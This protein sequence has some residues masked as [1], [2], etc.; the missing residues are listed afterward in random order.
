METEQIQAQL[1]IKKTEIRPHSNAISHNMINGCLCNAPKRQEL[2]KN[3]AGEMQR[4]HSRCCGRKGKFFQ[5]E[6][7]LCGLPRPCFH[8]STW[9]LYPPLRMG[10]A[11]IIHPASA[12]NW[13]LGSKLHCLSKHTTGNH[14]HNSLGRRKPGY[15]IKNL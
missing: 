13:H 3:S 6:L 2:E 8:Y 7:L 15:Y 10:K 1:S 11:A 12:H 14:L 4:S 9:D 5:T